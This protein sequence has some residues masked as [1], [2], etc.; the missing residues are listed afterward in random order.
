MVEMKKSQPFQHVGIIGAGAWG[1]AL[2]LTAYRAG[3]HVTLWAREPEV[4]ESIKNAREN[5]LFLP[6]VTVPGSIAVTGT[7]PDLLSCDLVLS[8][9]PAQHTT[10][11]LT[12]LAPDWPSKTPL[13]LASKGIEIATG[14]LLSEAAERALPGRPLAVLSGPTFASDTARNKPTAVTIAATH[15]SLAQ[16]VGNSL[17]HSHFRPYASVDPIGV[18]IG[19]ALKNVIAIACGMSEGL[20]YGE[21]ARAALMTRGLAEI[22]RFAS[23]FGATPETLMGLSGMGDLVLT[24]SS[25]TS[26][27]MSLGKAIGEGQALADITSQRSSVAEGVPTAEAIYKLAAERQIDMPICAAVHTILSGTAEITTTLDTL[28]ARPLKFETV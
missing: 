10:R 23:H 11:M 27:N 19:G 4:V 8:V 9:L 3:R 12:D 16:D 15:A 22:S 18:Q 13:V 28:L 1:T 5:K 2:A 24:C 21:N 25:T 7:A 26:R 14:R 17:S 6:G 20:N